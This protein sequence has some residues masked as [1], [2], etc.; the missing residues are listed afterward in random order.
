ML[1]C[2]TT[3]TLASFYVVYRISSNR[4]RPRIVAT[5]SKVLDRNKRHPRIVAAAS[6]HGTH[7]HV[8]MIS[9][10]G[11]HASTRTVCVVRVV[12]TTDSRTE[13]LCVPYPAT[14]DVSGLS[15]EINAALEY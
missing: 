14:I 2:K 9:D 4:R 5:Q 11:H 7:T 13:R 15:K 10:D 1:F 6:K 12:P 8:R 3:V